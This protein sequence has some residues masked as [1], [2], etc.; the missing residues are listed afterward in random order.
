MVV[1]LV[2]I[3]RR[4]EVQILSPLPINSRGCRQTATPFSLVFTLVLRSSSVAGN[5]PGERISAPDVCIEL[6]FICAAE[7]PT[8]GSNIMA[9]KKGYVLII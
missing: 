3:T 4:S 7:H 5:V 6:A 9:R 8:I 1:S 2:L